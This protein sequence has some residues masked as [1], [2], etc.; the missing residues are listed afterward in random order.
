VTAKDVGQG[1]T[2]SVAVIEA[3]GAALRDV[4]VGVDVGADGVVEPGGEL[5]LDLVTGWDLAADVDV[6]VGADVVADVESALDVVPHPAIT[7]SPVKPSP[8]H[9]TVRCRRTRPPPPSTPVTGYASTVRSSSRSAKRRCAS[10]RRV[11]MCSVGTSCATY[12]FSTR[13]A[14]VWRCTSSGPS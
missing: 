6:E 8:T 14:T 10:A 5:E 11:G 9:H 13:R 12:P 3:C 1:T 4:D 7:T 2:G